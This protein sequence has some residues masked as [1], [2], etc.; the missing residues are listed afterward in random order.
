[1]PSI[2]T[3]IRQRSDFDDNLTK[4]MGDV[5][6]E[7]CRDLHDKGQPL[8]VQEILAKRILDGVRRGERDPERLREAALSAIHSNT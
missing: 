8:I 4:L 6:D 7:V 5:F 2:L 1:M 3:F